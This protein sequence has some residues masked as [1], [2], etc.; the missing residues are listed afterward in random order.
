MNIAIN[1]FGRIGKLVFRHMFELGVQIVAINDLSS[2]KMLAYLLKYDTS[3]G[4]FKRDVQYNENS[5]IVD[6]KSIRVYAERDPAKIPWST[7]NVDIVIECT[8]FFTEY[9]KAIVHV[10]SGGAKRVI[11]SAP[12]AS[13]NVKTIVYNVN[14][15][16]LDGSETVISG[17]S[18]TTNCL[19]PVA[20]LLDEKIGIE[21][22]FM[23][24][25]HAYTNDQNVLDSA[26]PK[27]DLRRS[28]TCAS[29]I[30]PNST[31]AAKA[32]DLVLPNLKGKMAGTAQRVPT[33]TGSL[34]EL[35]AV[36]SRH[37][38]VVELNQIMSASVNESFG[39]TN[40]QI[41]SSDVVGTN[42]GALF[43]ATQTQVLPG[44][45]PFVKVV[46]W[47]DNEMSYVSQLVRTVVYWSK[48]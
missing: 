42:Y 34:I 46:A 25:I 16:I 31:G 20:K 18:C 2:P 38:T 5:I 47:Y 9:E 32:I 33:I 41:V 1:G 29:N 23:T 37:T 11:I 10:Y 17:A 44:M 24:T 7:H 35:T 43:D 30:I 36:L 4:T 22:G 45:I 40:D 15:T 14:H 13:P 19:A 8:G 6:G 12:T 48:L 26:H 27:G 28:R 21:A 3:Q 39:Y